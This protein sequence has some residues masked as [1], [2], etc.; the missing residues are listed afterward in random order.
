M[1]SIDLIIVAA[2]VLFFLLA[3]GLLVP[4]YFFLKREEK[5]SERWKDPFAAPSLPSAHPSPHVP[6]NASAHDRMN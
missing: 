4:I 3:A 2:L 5:A 1:N 6:G